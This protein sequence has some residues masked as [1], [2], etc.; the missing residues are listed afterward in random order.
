MNLGTGAAVWLFQKTPFKASQLRGQP[1]DSLRHE[2]RHENKEPAED[3]GPLLGEGVSGVALVCVAADG[4]ED[5]TKQ[6]AAPTDGAPDHGLERLVR[7]HFA[8]IDDPDLRHVKRPAKSGDDGCEDE[9]KQFELRR[10]VAGEEHPVFAVAN[11]ALNE[12]ELRRGEPTAEQIGAEQQ[13]A[14]GNVEGPLG[15]GSIDG[16]TQ[17]ELQTR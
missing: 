9:N 7:R 12:A 3:I 6:I 4:A 1:D 14:G 15:G 10:R 8:R 16:V 13:K 2:Q 11:G 17:D 5:G